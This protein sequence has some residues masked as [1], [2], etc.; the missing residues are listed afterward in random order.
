MRT[1]GGRQELT[2]QVAAR[3]LQPEPQ[4]LVGRPL[5]VDPDVAS[6]NRSHRPE[7]RRVVVLVPREYLQTNMEEIQET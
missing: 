4:A 1:D 7:L 6:P 2:V 5:R 3:Q